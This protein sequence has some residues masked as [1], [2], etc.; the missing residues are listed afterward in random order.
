MDDSQ[1]TLEMTI[2]IIQDTGDYKICIF[3]CVLVLNIALFL[4]PPSLG[5]LILVSNFTSYWG[6]LIPVVLL[7]RSQ[8]IGVNSLKKALD[9]DF[10]GLLTSD[11]VNRY[12]FLPCW[13]AW[14]HWIFAMNCYTFKFFFVTKHPWCFGIRSSYLWDFLSE[15]CMRNR[16]PSSSPGRTCR[17][18]THLHGGQIT[19]L[20]FKR[21]CTL[22]GRHPG[23]GTHRRGVSRGCHWESWYS[24]WGQ[25]TVGNFSTF[26]KWRGTKISQPIQRMIPEPSLH[27]LNQNSTPVK[28]FQQ[29]CSDACRTFCCNDIVTITMIKMDVTVTKVVVT[30]I[31]NGNYLD[32][33]GQFTVKSQFVSDL[34]KHLPASVTWH[35]AFE[36]CSFMFFP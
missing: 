17:L 8:G 5:W 15:L 21:F 26:P 33:L 10:E 27:P 24:F 11:M 7:R 22:S 12:G 1:M 25:D 29:S 19:G 28:V 20:Q 34:R 3:T 30:P 35:L 6:P 9:Q 18:P 4:I 23:T 13:I 2:Q 32:T 36:T 31:D 16:K 14:S